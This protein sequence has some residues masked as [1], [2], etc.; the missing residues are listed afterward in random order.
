MHLTWTRRAQSS[1]ATASSHSIVTCDHSHFEGSPAPRRG[2]GPEPAPLVSVRNLAKAYGGAQALCGVDLDLLPGEVH[3]LVGANGAGKST[4]VRILAGVVSP[5]SGT[6]SIAGQEKVIRSPRQAADFG[7][8]FIHQELNLV[9]KFSALQNI[10]LGRASRRRW[11]MLL[12]WRA[13]RK[14]TEEVAA[15]V[16]I[17]FPLDVPVH[18]LSVA[19][20][21]LVSIARALLG[22]AKVIAM[23][24]PTASLSAPEAER[25]FGLVDHLSQSGVTIIYVS[26]RL[27]EILQL[28]DRVTVLKDGH[29]V[30]TLAREAVTKDLLV[31]AIAGKDPAAVAIERPPERV[32]GKPVLQAVG[33]GRG[34]AVNDV[35]FTLHEGEVL[36]IAG[37]VGAGRTELAR[38]LFGADRADR[39]EVRVNGTRI[40]LR[41]PA[42][43]IKHGIVLVPE[44]RRSQGLVLAKSIQFNVALPNLRASYVARGLP[45][46]SGRKTRRRAAA[47][48]Q[49]LL[50]KAESSALHVRALSGGN[51]QKVVIGKWLDERVRVFILDEPTRG[52]D[53]GARAEIHGLIRRLANSGSGVLVISSEFEELVGCDRVLVIVDGRIVGELTGPSITEETM[54]RACYG[55]GVAA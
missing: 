51:Q 29:C 35:S 43:A 37:V 1:Q 38:L 9:P 41:S 26:H 34:T 21:W 6:V 40:R 39:G 8:A 47:R 30:T 16:G 12:D 52:V 23:D 50:I 55:T 46:V 42:D 44:E 5:D 27:D 3:G 4:L 10:N 45:L 2:A 22:D 31:E 13:I 17:D 18:R 32:S 11:R 20:R 7:F 53:V 54:L 36:G 49:D 24:E 33:L 48:I 14:E 28:C 19:Q 15:R 25:L